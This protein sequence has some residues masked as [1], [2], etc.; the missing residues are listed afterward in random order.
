MDP[1]LCQVDLLSGH[2]VPGAVKK[3]TSYAREDKLRML[4]FYKENSNNLYRTCQKFN[5]N[6]K[7]LLRWLKD[8]IR[9]VKVKEEPSKAT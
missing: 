1:A 6:S 8:E 4:A 2:L 3:H 7:N 9:Y 5:I